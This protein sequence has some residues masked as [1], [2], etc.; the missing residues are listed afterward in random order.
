VAI[1]LIAVELMDFELIDKAD[2]SDFN[3][4]AAGTVAVRFA[5]AR[6]SGAIITRRNHAHKNFPSNKVIKANAQLRIV[7]VIHTTGASHD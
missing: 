4:R 6:F 7:P 3:Y 2:Y 1:E 5:L